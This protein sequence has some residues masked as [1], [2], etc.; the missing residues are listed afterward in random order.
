VAVAIPTISGTISSGSH[1]GPVSPRD[2]II[3][4]LNIPTH[5]LDRSGNGIRQAYTKYLAYIDAKN[6]MDKVVADGKWPLTKAPTHEDIVEVFISK[7][8]FFKNYQPY[9]PHIENHP[10]LHRWLKN[11]ANPPSDIEAWG[12]A[13]NVYMFRDLK[14]YLDRASKKEKQGVQEG[15]SSHK[16]KGD[17]STGKKKATKA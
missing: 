8:A 14:D 15:S 5:L 9:F 6:A 7:S 16:K 4:I 10:S 12:V 11:D 3:S 2:H 17:K 1:A 13:K